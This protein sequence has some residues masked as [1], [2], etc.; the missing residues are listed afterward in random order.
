MR[1]SRRSA[2]FF[3]AVYMLICNSET[4]PRLPTLFLS[5]GKE[6]VKELLGD[7]RSSHA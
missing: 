5:L 1:S 3:K 4:G 7:S 2:R 6:R